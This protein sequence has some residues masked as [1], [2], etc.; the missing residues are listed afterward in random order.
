MRISKRQLKI[1]HF[2]LLMKILEANLNEVN[3]SGMAPSG[4][5]LA[6][7]SN[8][9]KQFHLLSIKHLFPYSSLLKIPQGSMALLKRFLCC[10]YL[11]NMQER[12]TVD[13][14]KN[15]KLPNSTR[16]LRCFSDSPVPEFL[17]LK[18]VP[19]LWSGQDSSSC[20][21]SYKGS[22]IPP[23]FPSGSQV[24]LSTSGTYPGL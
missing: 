14:Q 3:V 13:F 7:H 5:D 17:F 15:Q 1:P 9:I 21:K 8:Q 4:A 24:S 16:Y 6:T 11:F 19:K 2:I 22:N 10:L 18:D 12:K 23:L 20:Y